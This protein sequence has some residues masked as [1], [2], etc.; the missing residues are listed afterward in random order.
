MSNTH[1]WSTV[2]ATVVVV[3]VILVSSGIEGAG[4]RNQQKQTF[5]K[6]SDGTA[7]TCCS[8]T[9]SDSTGC[10]HPL[11]VK[12]SRLIRCCSEGEEPSAVEKRSNDAEGEIDVI[13][14][15]S[16]EDQELMEKHKSKIPYLTEAAK[17]PTGEHES[18][19]KELIDEVKTTKR[20]LQDYFLQARAQKD[21]L[22]RLAAEM[23]VLKRILSTQGIQQV[24]SEDDEESEDTDDE[25]DDNEI[26]KSVLDDI[27]LAS[28]RGIQLAKAM[29]TARIKRSAAKY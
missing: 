15:L 12:R 27:S 14:A 29:E 3:V 13:S 5:E 17:L 7:L 4:L 8:C 11:D 24:D 9:S 6:R 26:V 28:K 20:T 25:I 22:T 19:K 1:Y 16:P 10:Y 18:D 21:S 2:S 23:D